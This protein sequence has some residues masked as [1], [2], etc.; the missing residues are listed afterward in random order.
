M[1]RIHLALTLFYP[2]IA[3]RTSR[4]IPSEILNQKTISRN[5]IAMMDDIS[6]YLNLARNFEDLFGNPY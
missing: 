6:L 4:F 2:H 1:P 3:E 5:V